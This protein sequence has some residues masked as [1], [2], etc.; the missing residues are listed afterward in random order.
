M[1]HALAFGW[2]LMAR[3]LLLSLLPSKPSWCRIF[4]AV[5]DQ[6]CFLYCLLQEGMDPN[7][8]DE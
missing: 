1:A 4:H 2:K 3:M 6:Q 5:M 8:I 7:N